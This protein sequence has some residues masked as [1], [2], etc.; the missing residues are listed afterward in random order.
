MRTRGALGAVLAVVAVVVPG[1]AGAHG[2][3]V[4][5]TVTR[6]VEV[7]LAVVVEATYHSGR[8]MAGAQVTVFAPGASD[9]PWLV[10]ECDGTGRF[11]FSPP[12]DLSGAWD[13]RVVHHGHG[14]RVAVEVA[15]EGE[16]AGSAVVRAQ[17]SSTAHLTTLQ[18]S[19]MA[20]CVIWGL[21]GTALFFSRRR[22]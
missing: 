3:D 15:G 1:L 2:A 16:E 4:V 8:P 13:V 11:E 12:V 21:V 10:G 19:V 20:A 9:E 22:G 14:G 17:A 6:Q 7:E 5:A 18:R